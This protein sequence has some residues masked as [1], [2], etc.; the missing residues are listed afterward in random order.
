M[1]AQKGT[2]GVVE[3]LATHA[4]SMIRRKKANKS[5]R[6]GGGTHVTFPASSVLILWRGRDVVPQLSQLEKAVRTAI[7]DCSPVS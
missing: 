3:M 5:T 6:N 2:A 7:V 1:A 4:A